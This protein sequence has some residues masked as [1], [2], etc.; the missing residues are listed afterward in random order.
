MQGIKLFYVV[1]HLLELFYS[2]KSPQKP[3]TWICNKTIIKYIMY[4][5]RR[6]HIG[7]Y[8]VQI[9][10]NVSRIESVMAIQKFNCKTLQNARWVSH[11][12]NTLNLISNIQQS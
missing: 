11:M 6:I 3:K 10:G 1:L 7:K 9:L 2:Q 8:T 12:K 5:N 4:Q